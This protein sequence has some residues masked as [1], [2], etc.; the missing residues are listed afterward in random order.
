MGLPIRVFSDFVQ[1]LEIAPLANHIET[2]S[3]VYDN[4]VVVRH[5]HI[6]DVIYYFTRNDPISGIF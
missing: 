4:F 3:I 5:S 2:G 6:K 1:S